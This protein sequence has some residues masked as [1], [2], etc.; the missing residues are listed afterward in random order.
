MVVPQK[1]E[2]NLADAVNQKARRRRRTLFKKASEYSSECG[3][4]IHIVLRMKKSGKIFI[5]TSNSEGW[6]L[7]QNQLVSF[8]S[9]FISSL[10]RY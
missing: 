3:A 5:L 2:T 10:C 1:S 8:S 9:L 6:P 7:S 4:D